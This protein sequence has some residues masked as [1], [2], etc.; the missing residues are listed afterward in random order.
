MHGWADEDITPSMRG[1]AGYCAR[2]EG[3]SCCWLGRVLRGITHGS[4]FGLRAAA[5]LQLF[6]P[7]VM[8]HTAQVLH[9][10]TATHALEAI[11]ARIEQPS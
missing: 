5:R 4:E 3:S 1:G 2:G 8:Q 7:K 10:V 11:A 6:T 9:C